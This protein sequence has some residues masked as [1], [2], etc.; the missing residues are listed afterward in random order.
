MKVLHVNGPAFPMS[1]PQ[2]GTHVPES[3]LLGNF[4]YTEVGEVGA[5]VVVRPFL[6][7][8]PALEHWVALSHLVSAL[9]PKEDVN[10]PVVLLHSWGI[11]SRTAADFVKGAAE[12]FPRAQVEHVSVLRSVSELSGLRKA[13][14]IFGSMPVVV[15]P[16]MEGKVTT[17]P[18]GVTCPLVRYSMSPAAC[19]DAVERM[20]PGN[21][22]FCVT[23]TEDC[24]EFTRGPNLEAPGLPMSPVPMDQFLAALARGEGEEIYPASS[25]VQLDVD[26]PTILRKCVKEAGGDDALADAAVVAFQTQKMDALIPKEGA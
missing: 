18:A 24:M 8:Q 22:S 13:K 1:D 2:R 19:D 21:P 9:V 26:Q 3:V 12:F 5:L 14:Q 20:A 11:G 10:F 25:T 7:P 23:N 15:A 17:R 4:P 16:T 6:V